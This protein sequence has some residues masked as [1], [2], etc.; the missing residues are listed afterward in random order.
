M[1]VYVNCY[2]RWKLGY[3]LI[4]RFMFVFKVKECEL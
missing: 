4:R 3:S 2:Y 1:W